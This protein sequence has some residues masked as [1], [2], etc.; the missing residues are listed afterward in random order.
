MKQPSL[1]ANRQNFG[2]D[3]NFNAR[4]SGFCKGLWEYRQ[5]LWTFVEVEG[6]E[7]TNNAAE[8]A[9]LPGGAP[10]S[11]FVGLESPPVALR[12]RRAPSSAL[13]SLE[14]F[15]LPG[16]AEPVQVIDAP[17]D[18]EGLADFVRRVTLDA[19]AA[20]PREIEPAGPR[21]AEVCEVIRL[22]RITWTGGEPVA[23]PLLRDA[24]VK[25]NSN[26]EGVSHVGPKQRS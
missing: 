22:C 6:V 8:Q 25:R 3:N 9:A 18:G 4:V 19:Y 16:P 5:N 10:G 11:V 26:P 1:L 15:P 17:G 20:D 21:L 13:A 24:A 23:P 2:E 7:P 14:D 12:G